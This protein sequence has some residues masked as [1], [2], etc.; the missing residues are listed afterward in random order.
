MKRGYFETLVGFFVIITAIFFC[1]FVTK[2]T[3]KKID[4]N[5]YN[6]YAKFENIEGLSIGSKVKIGGLDI[7][8][9]SS[10]IIDRDYKV[11]LLLKINSDV[12]IPVDSTIT[13]STSGIIGGKYLK[14][15]IGGSDEFMKNNDEFEFTQSTMDLE[16]MITKFMFNKTNKNQ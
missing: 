8:S 6:V 14:V 4:I 7:G 5:T 16:E 1:I 11:K 13:V 9:I 2:V 10:L 12:S 3:G 15:Q